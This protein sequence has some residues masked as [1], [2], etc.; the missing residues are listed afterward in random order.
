MPAELVAALRDRFGVPVVVRYT[1]TEASLGTGTD[2]GDPDEVVAT[3]VGRPVPGV[4]LAIV[5]EDGSEVGAGEV[6]RV[7]IRSGAVMLGYWG[8]PPTGPGIDGVVFDA[9]ATR[10]VLDDDGWL[11]TGD[12]GSVDTGGNL[13]L[14]GRANEMYIRGGYNVYPAEVES[15]LSTHP[16][17]AQVAVV[18]TPDPVLGEIGVAFVVPAE[19]AG[20]SLA[21]LRSWAAGSL[22]DYKSPDR[23]AVVESLPVTSMM[24]VDKRALARPAAEAAAGDRHLQSTTTARNS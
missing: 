2:P 12:F 6:G 1:S 24:K 5:D 7:R 16:A 4:S 11:T 19:D 23:L 17:V 3:T 14:V 22:A 13:H 9:A 21:D 18:G 15:A 10:S 20:V 8:G